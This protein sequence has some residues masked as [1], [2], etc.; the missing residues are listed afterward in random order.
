MP[1]PPSPRT[2]LLRR[3]A[4]AP[5]FHPVF[6]IFQ[7]PPLWG[8]KLKFTFPP[9]KR[10]G[11]W[12]GGVQT[13]NVKYRHIMRIAPQLSVN[14]KISFVMDSGDLLGLLFLLVPMSNAERFSFF[15]RL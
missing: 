14:N 9:L 3:A 11:G 1:E 10:R 6:L 12:G 7:I 15:L 13:M 8:R 4:P 2:P 5:Y